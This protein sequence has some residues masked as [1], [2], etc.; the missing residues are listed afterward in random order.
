MNKALDTAR[1]RLGSRAKRRKLSPQGSRV[2]AP[3][4]AAAARPWQGG[5]NPLRGKASTTAVPSGTVVMSGDRRSIKAP[6]RKGKDRDK[7][8]SRS[9][10][11][12][13]LSMQRRN[14]ISE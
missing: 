10:I 4:H 1:T 6:Q 12:R 2:V 11:G 9:A 8:G 13:S 7:Y 5:T 14:Y 3:G